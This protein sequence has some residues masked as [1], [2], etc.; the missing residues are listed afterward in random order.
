MFCSNCGAEINDKA[1]VCVKCGVLIRQASVVSC[2]TRSNEW[3]T[4]VLLCIFLGCFGVHRFYMQDN[5][6]AVVQLILGLISCCIISQ[7]WALI[8]LILL[9][10]GK[11]NT[12]DGRSIKQN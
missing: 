2:V 3:L 11:F 7:I 1:V 4:A 10:T 8:D 9:L 12:E 6:I 5:K